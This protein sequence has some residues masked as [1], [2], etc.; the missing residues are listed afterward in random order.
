[1]FGDL[2]RFLGR[3][4]RSDSVR[5]KSHYPREVQ[6]LYGTLCGVVYRVTSLGLACAFGTYLYCIGVVS[7]VKK[8]YIYIFI[9]TENS[10]R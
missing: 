6:R 10:S 2:T 5:T 4:K 9:Y 1:M 3:W 7:G 8:N